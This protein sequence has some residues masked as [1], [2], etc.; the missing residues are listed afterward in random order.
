MYGS[1]NRVLVNRSGRIHR[2]SHHILFP[3]GAAAAD[4]AFGAN[5]TAAHLFQP[6]AKFNALL[7]ALA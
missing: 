6:T 5:V 7:F 1:T 3:P 2:I 4:P